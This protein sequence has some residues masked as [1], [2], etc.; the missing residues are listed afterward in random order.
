MDRYLHLTGLSFLLLFISLS[1][2]APSNTN[3]PEYIKDLAIYREGEDG[4]FIYLVLADKADQ[5]TASKGILEFAISHDN[6]VCEYI[7][8][9]V[10]TNDFQ[11][12][13]ISMGP[14]K[15]DTIL[16]PIGRFHVKGFWVIV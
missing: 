2:G 16:L 15:R 10:N 4:I 12:T 14:C 1:C 11:K 5:P 6:R 9:K 3:T 13:E 8:A 7:V